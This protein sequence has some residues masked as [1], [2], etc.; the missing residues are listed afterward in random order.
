MTTAEATSE[1][2]WTA[3]R[4]LPKRERETVV[5]RMLQDKEF[6]EDLVDIVVLEQRRHEPS[7]TLEEYL[8]DRKKKGK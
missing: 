4:G 6:M 2:F 8:A 1:V 7:R 5:K 3:F